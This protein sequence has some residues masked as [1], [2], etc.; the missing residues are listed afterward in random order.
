MVLVVPLQWEVVPGD[1]SRTLA[2]GAG[3][4]EENVKGLAV[5][6]F[7]RVYYLGPIWRVRQPPRNVLR[8]QSPKPA[9]RLAEGSVDGI[10]ATRSCLRTSTE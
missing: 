8:K 3:A 9:K 4:D 7:I 6:G 1:T 5:V 10:S 2:G